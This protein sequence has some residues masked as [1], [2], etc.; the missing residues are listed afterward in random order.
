MRRRPRPV[1][2]LWRWHRRLGVLAAFFALVLA[3]TG[4]VLNHSAELEL[5]RRF[6]DWP[7]LSQAYGD[8][9]GDLPAFQL[10]GHWLSRAANGRVYFDAREV[11]PCSGKLVG[12]VASGELLY[13]GCA[14]ELLLLTGGGELIESINASTGLPVPVQAVGLI[15]SRSCCRPPGPGGWPIW[16]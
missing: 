12:A 9:S 6:V 14:E 13:A 11:A 15:D 16:T 10:G 5:D 7:W 3:T 4:I 8:G 2:L 1:G